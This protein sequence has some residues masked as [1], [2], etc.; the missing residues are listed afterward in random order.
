VN[1][2]GAVE[3]L[4]TTGIVRR[5]GTDTWTASNAV[6]NAELQNSTITIGSVST[7]LGGTLS[8]AT[9]RASTAL[10]IDSATGVGDT[11]YT[12]LTTDRHVFTNAAFTATRTWTLPAANT[13]NPGQR[14][15]IGDLQG[16]ITATNLLIIQRAGA[17]TINGTTA[18][19]LSSASTSLEVVSDG[20]SKWYAVQ[21]GS[22]S[23]GGS[24]ISNPKNQYEFV[25][26]AS[27]TTFSGADQNAKTLSYTVGNVEIY[28][29]GLRLNKSDYT[30]STGSTVVLAL[31]ANVGDLLTI[32]DC[33]SG[34]AASFTSFEYTASA[35]QTTFSGADINAKTLAYVAGFVLVYVNGDLLNTADYTATNGTSVVFAV[36]RALNDQV[37][38]ISM[39]QSAVALIPSNNL[40]DVASTTTAR[41]N[42]GLPNL[43]RGY[44]QGLTLSTAGA[45]ATFGIAAGVADDS[46]FTDFMLLSSAF[47]KT[48]SAWAVGTGNGAMDTGAVAINTWY[49]V[50]VIKRVDTGLVDILFSLSASAPTMPASYTLFRRIGSMKTNGSSQW[51]AFNQLGDEFLWLASVADVASATLTAGTPVLETL[52]VPTGLQVIAKFDAA[53]NLGSSAGVLINSPDQTAVATPVFPN[54][55]MINAAAGGANASQFNI[56]T[57][58][59]AQVRAAATA[60]ITTNFSITT[61]GWTDYRGRI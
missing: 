32:V 37:K 1:D 50:Y 60:T 53:F 29:N 47:T 44:I 8:A 4:A 48:T 35:A 58:T 22:G 52:S 9:G 51:I 39:N 28:N 42:L 54:V 49:H 23:G 16:T 20:T 56:R 14:I 41:Q 55:N 7:A 33:G 15:L 27:Q 3:G 10:N 2:L 34:G 13:V 5:T 25:A 43:L 6:T 12:I 36:G 40:S 18:I 59:S 45:S 46:T 21:S 31:P 11:N 19:T 24:G 61:Q 38:I 57:N 17:D 26:T 30:A